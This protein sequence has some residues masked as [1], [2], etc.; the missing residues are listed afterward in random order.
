MIARIVLT[1]SHYP[2]LLST[3]PGM[4]SRQPSVSAQSWWTWFFDSQ[5]TLVYP[6]VG[7]HE[8]SRFVRA[9]PYDEMTSCW[10]W[11]VGTSD[12]SHLGER[13][14]L[15]V[16]WRKLLWPK[17]QC[18]NLKIKSKERLFARNIFKCQLW[19]PDHVMEDGA[20]FLSTIAT[21]RDFPLPFDLLKTRKR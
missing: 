7:A 4:C 20:I 8:R 11:L 21:I 6:Y 14:E 15:L 19:N 16:G 3:A 9:P 2:S 12:K 1:L 10:I 17:F 5:L 13:K 18:W